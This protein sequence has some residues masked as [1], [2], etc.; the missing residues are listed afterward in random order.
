MVFKIQSNFIEHSNFYKYFSELGKSYK[1]IYKMG[2][3]YI[4][5]KE[6]GS[7]EHEE[8]Y[9]K[10]ILKPNNQFL[11][12]P[13]T[14]KNIMREDEEIKSWCR[15]NLVRLDTEKF[16]QEQQMKLQEIMENLDKMESILEEKQ[17]KEG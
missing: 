12:T 5:L 4:A 1:M 3:L 9:I 2:V 7:L 14:E 17:R 13:I 15:D 6:Y 8:K 11:I 10:K 16:E